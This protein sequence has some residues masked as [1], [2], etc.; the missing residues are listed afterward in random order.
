MLLI[1]NYES[2]RLNAAGK[3]SEIYAGFLS[4]IVKKGSNL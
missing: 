1:G 3:V 2:V 4:I